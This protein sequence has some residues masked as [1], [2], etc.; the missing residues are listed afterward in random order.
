[1]SYFTKYICFYRLDENKTLLLN[2]ITSAIDIVDNDTYDKIQRMIN[3]G[4]NIDDGSLCN[5][6]KSRGYIFEDVGEE[7]K[8]I[9]KLITIN[10][11]M[12]YKRI[13]YRFVICPTTGCNLR[14]TYCFE[15]EKQHKKIDLLSDG[16]LATIFN[17]I[18]NCSTKY[19][20]QR[21]SEL[22]TGNDKLPYITLFGGEP[23]LKCNFHVV[24]KILNFAHKMKMPV[25]IVTNGTTIGDSYYK[26]LK[27]YKD[28][29]N[30]I[31]VTMD[32]NKSIH[33]KRRIRADGGGTFERIC[34]G[35]NKILEIGIK[36]DL[37]INVDAENINY[38]GELKGIFEEQGWL[39]NPLFVPYAAPVR[40]Y[41]HNKKPDSVM[42]D[43]SMLNDMIEKGFYGKDNSFLNTLLSPV[44][45]IVADFFNTSG[46]KIKPFKQTYCEGTAGT[47]YC[48]TPDGNISTCLTCVGKED[49]RVG[50]FDENGVNIDKYRLEK[51]TCRDPF[52]ITKCK[53]CKYI[54]LCG[55]GC[56]YEALENN[57]DINCPE[58]D[59]IKNVLEVYVKHIKDKLLRVTKK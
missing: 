57:H 59:D 13:P 33:D 49:Y 42:T 12:R 28:N 36:I 24:E 2:T 14:C 9:N 55:G 41:N 22:P 5:K 46:D 31:Q 43:S 34:D 30:T 11:R 51:W 26:L 48:F 15:G 44:Y 27:R 54:F 50:T 32:G 56:P 8:Q 58:C 23:L 3:Y 7:K 25:A 38:L 40:C 35:I 47:Q 45:N 29:L 10:Q 21:K 16:Q 20:E 19:M 6:L 1:M 37:R 17:Y 4:E 39:E 18:K 52:E 53:D